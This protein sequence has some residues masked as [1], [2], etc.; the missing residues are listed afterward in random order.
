[1]A[2]APNTTIYILAG[3]PLNNSYQHTIY[4]S[5]ASYQQT[6]FL[7]KVKYT[8]TNYTYQRYASNTIRV[9]L[10]ADNLYDCNYLMFQNTNYGNKWFYAF[11][12]SVEYINDTTAQITYEID[13]IQTYHFDYE[14]PPCFVVREH[15]VTDVAGQNLVPE[16]LEQGDY[17]E[18]GADEIGIYN[19]MSVS[20]GCITFMCTFENDAEHGFPQSGGHIRDGYYT[21]LN[22]VS[23]YGN[24]L[25]ENANAWLADVIAANKFEGIIAV[26]QTPFVPPAT[27]APQVVQF[28][29]P[30]V[31]F[32]DYTPKN[33]KLQT[34]PYRLLHVTT[35]TN[36][37][38][39]HYEY[40]NSPSYCT[41]LTT[42]VIVPEPSV[43]LIPTGYATNQ[44]EPQTEYRLTLTNYPQAAISAD[45]Y[46]VYLAQNAASMPVKMISTTA[47]AA[48]AVVGAI[49]NPANI[50]QAAAGI[51]AIAGEVA[52]L[53]DIKTKPSQVNGSQIGSLDYI[54]NYKTFFARHLRIRKEAAMIIDEYFSMYG[55]A[56]HRVKIPNRNSRPYWNYVKTAN[57][58]VK[59]TLP[60]ATATHIQN[61]YDTGITFWKSGGNVGNYA[62][63]NSPT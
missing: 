5:A 43:N 1:M 17:V 12:N 60:A 33:A 52:Q 18:C 53:H 28:A 44:T 38:D 19:Q 15:S 41:F 46:Q 32:G 37:A 9:A 26:Y 50:G 58:L 49:I 31:A 6:Y 11:I 42:A 48:G 55:Y 63:D 61:I 13:D 27:Q 22:P 7:T 45:N 54:A 62:L 21:C 36:S 24:D 29:K 59:G 2:V 4:F 34:F 3:V 40:F 57:C 14:I 35:D 39:F 8:L 56:T 10:T 51:G 20:I 47:A 16:N 23:F 25:I 30:G